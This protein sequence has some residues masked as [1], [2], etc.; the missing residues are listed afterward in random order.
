MAF[1]TTN[2][3]PQTPDQ[4]DL[5]PAVAIGHVS[6]NVSN[7]QKS[8]EFFEFI[9]M[10]K[11]VIMSGMAILELRGGTHLVLSKKILPR[12]NKVNFDLMVDDLNAH[13]QTLTNAGYITTSIKRGRVHYSF[14]VTEPSGHTITFNDSHVAGPV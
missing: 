2:T 7:F 13:H 11:I 6:L 10:R 12:P 9:G 14:E 5:R 3:L 8:L 4:T 1:T